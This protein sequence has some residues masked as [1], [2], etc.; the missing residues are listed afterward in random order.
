[1]TAQNIKA[2]PQKTND[3]PLGTVGANAAHDKPHTE[4]PMKAKGAP[5]VTKP[6]SESFQKPEL[7]AK[8][9]PGAHEKPSAP[10]KAPEKI[11]SAAKEKAAEA[12]SD[13][14]QATQEAGISHNESVKASQKA[15][16]LPVEA[17]WGVGSALFSLARANG[18]A[19]DAMMRCL[20][21]S[22]KGSAEMSQCIASCQ[23]EY[24]EHMQNLLAATRNWDGDVGSWTQ[25]QS[26]AFDGA[27]QLYIKQ[28]EDMMRIV[29]RSLH[30][31]WTPFMAF[32]SA[33]ER[34]NAMR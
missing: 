26:K 14:P 31:G 13:R 8:P 5:T 6:Q 25:T 12:K 24:S 34:Q 7:S 23:E 33:A 15:A 20:E 2:E 19:M 16:E 22:L 28:A 9:H 3:I 17:F 29:N 27:A 1:M 11:E 30:Q 32:V 4:S 10:E 21:A 18:E